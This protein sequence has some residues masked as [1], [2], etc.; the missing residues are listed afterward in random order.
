MQI[1]LESKPYKDYKFIPKEKKLIISERYVNVDI[2]DIEYAGYTIR[3]DAGY[4]ILTTNKGCAIYVSFQ[5]IVTTKSNCIIEAGMRSNITTGNECQITTHNECYIKIGSRC[6][7][8]TRD[9]CIIH[10][11]EYFDSYKNIF[12]LGNDNII[13]LKKF[14]DIKKNTFTKYG[15]GNI[16]IGIEDGTRLLMDENFERLMKVCD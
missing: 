9:K 1:S 4:G 8:K 3:M 5:S 2:S 10:M 12:E 13:I 16:I 14:D 11:N 6:G 7:V 15:K